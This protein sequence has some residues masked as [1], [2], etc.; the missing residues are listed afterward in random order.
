MDFY[1]DLEIV[2][3]VELYVVLA[4]M[5]QKTS[6]KISLFLVKIRLIIN[7]QTSFTAAALASVGGLGGATVGRLIVGAGRIL[8][9][10]MPSCETNAAGAPRIVP[11]CCAAGN[12]GP[13]TEIGGD[14]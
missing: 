2:F 3:Q 8:I 14:L 10:L 1:N 5:R 7:E 13:A 11:K 6:C 12:V 4:V 9:E